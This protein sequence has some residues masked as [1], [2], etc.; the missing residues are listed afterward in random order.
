MSLV[1]PHD[2]MYLNTDAPNERVQDTGRL[3]MHTARAPDHPDYRRT[4]DLAPPAS[5]TQRFDEPGRPRAHGEYDKAWGYTL[6]HVPLDEA[7]WR[8]FNDYYVNCIRAVD[9][10][11]ATIVQELD[12]QGLSR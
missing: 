2:I 1:N 7:R 3:M 9:A 11:V 8:R 12:A 10:Q 6:G 4:W 5:L